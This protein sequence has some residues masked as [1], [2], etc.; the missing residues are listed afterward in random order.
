MPQ[1][2]PSRFYESMRDM[3][4]IIARSRSQSLQEREQAY[5]E[6]IFAQQMKEVKMEAEQEEM[7]RKFIGGIAQQAIKG[8]SLEGADMSMLPS[9]A[10]NSILD[11][12]IS[13]KRLKAQREQQAE[14]TSTE[15]QTAQELS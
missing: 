10:L 3:P 1:I 15:T 11:Y 14:E 5:R 12:A 13:E 4:E 9:S 2:M 8:T 6:S 7:R